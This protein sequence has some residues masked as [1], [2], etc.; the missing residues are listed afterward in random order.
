MFITVEGVSFS[1]IVTEDNSH[2]LVTLSI[3]R[4]TRITC[5]LQLPVA[6]SKYRIKTTNII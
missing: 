5:R 2:I 1:C 3:R 4:N 6:V